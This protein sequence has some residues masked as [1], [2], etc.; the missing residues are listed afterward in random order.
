MIF[1]YFTWLE[2]MFQG[3]YCLPKALEANSGLVNII[4][5]MVNFRHVCLNEI[6]ILTCKINVFYKILYSSLFKADMR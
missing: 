4:N 1:K 5:I 2:H 3:H 6:N